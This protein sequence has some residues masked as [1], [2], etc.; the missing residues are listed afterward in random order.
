MSG[1]ERVARS[2]LN[3]IAIRHNRCIT[4]PRSVD[5]AGVLEQLVDHAGTPHSGHHKIALT[6]VDTEID[7][8]DNNDRQD[9]D[10]KVGGSK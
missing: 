2:S 4:Y 6:L 10:H 3:G 7:K 9:A 5:T 1:R 8:S